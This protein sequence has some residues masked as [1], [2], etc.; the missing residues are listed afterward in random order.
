MPAQLRSIDLHLQ[1]G[2]RG[3]SRVIT[4]PLQ[5][6]LTPDRLTADG[7]LPLKQ[8]DLGITPFSAML[9]ALQVQDEMH[10]RVH[11]LAHASPSRR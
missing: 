3:Q 2:V 5:Y 11:L 8:T 4:V 7:D 10:L 6:E 1:T 9:G